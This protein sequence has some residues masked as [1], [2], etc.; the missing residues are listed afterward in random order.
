[1]DECKD[2]SLVKKTNAK[3]IRKAWLSS[4]QYRQKR[5]GRFLEYKSFRGVCGCQDILLCS[6]VALTKVEY[7]EQVR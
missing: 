6:L 7:A 1:M 2:V 5:T 4:K 3:S